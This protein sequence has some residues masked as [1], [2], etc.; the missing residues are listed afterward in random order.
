MK[1]P[2]RKNPQHARRTTASRHVKGEWIEITRE[3]D[4]TGKDDV[5]FPQ[6]C[7]QLG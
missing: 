3:T 1:Q 2:C 7:G 4:G 6:S 5:A